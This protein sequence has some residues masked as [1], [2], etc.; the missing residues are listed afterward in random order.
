MAPRDDH[1]SDDVELDDSNSEESKY[2]DVESRR[3]GS[4]MV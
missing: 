3:S 1:W 4:R 2:D